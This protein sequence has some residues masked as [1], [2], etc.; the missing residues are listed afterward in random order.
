MAHKGTASFS[1]SRFTLFSSRKREDCNIFGKWLIWYYGMKGSSNVKPQQFRPPLVIAHLSVILVTAESP[2]KR[3]AK[4]LNLCFRMTLHSWSSPTSFY[5]NLDDKSIFF[6]RDISSC[7]SVFHSFYRRAL[8]WERGEWFL[9]AI[10]Q[11][12]SGCKM[13]KHHMNNISYNFQ[14][15][16]E[17]KE[18]CLVEELS[19]QLESHST[20][21]LRSWSK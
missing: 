12:L 2:A 13:L 17:R 7:V 16:L 10:V 18:K 11:Y 1:L 8:I 21:L 19:S 15:L 4:I 5:Y 20:S 9:S 14:L 3:G 6:R